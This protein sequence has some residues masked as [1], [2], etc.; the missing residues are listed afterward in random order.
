MTPKVQG[1]KKKVH[2]PA[3][4]DSTQG[5]IACKT[6]ARFAVTNDDPP[7]EYELFAWEI[8]QIVNEDLKKIGAGIRLT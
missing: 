8:I 4:P 7:D 2:P 6:W 1:K 3:W 5:R